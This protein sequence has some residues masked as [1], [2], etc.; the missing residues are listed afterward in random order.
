MPE[1]AIAIITL[2]GSQRMTKRGRKVISEWLRK[3]ADAL[4]EDGPDYAELF[5][6]RYLV[7]PEKAAH[8]RDFK[9]EPVA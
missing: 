1:K 6:A 2:R 3:Q 8:V 5:T 4:L 9:I 7:D